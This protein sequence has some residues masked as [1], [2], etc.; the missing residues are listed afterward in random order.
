MKDFFKDVKEDKTITSAFSVNVLFIIASI[1]YISFTYKKLPPLIPIFN[2]LPWGEQRL[3][4]QIMIFIPVLVALLIFATNICISVVAYKK[5][6]LL[7]RMLAAISLLAGIL[8]FLF[9]A[10]IITLII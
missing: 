8:V 5:N 7:S 10:R 1:I 3:G 2:Q 6:P 4:N 9:I